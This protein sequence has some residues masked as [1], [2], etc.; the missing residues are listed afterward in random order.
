M[1]PWS[2][3]PKQNKPEWQLWATVKPFQSTGPHHIPLNQLGHSWHWAGKLTLLSAPCSCTPAAEQ[4][5]CAFPLLSG[6]DSLAREHQLCISSWTLQSH[7]QCLRL[8]ALW[9]TEKNSS[10]KTWIGVTHLLKFY[11]TCKAMLLHFFL[12]LGLKDTRITIN[13]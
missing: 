6:R 12:K 3:C 11:K 5:P 10:L 4:N 8:M 9:S 7:L 13:P 1:S 2:R